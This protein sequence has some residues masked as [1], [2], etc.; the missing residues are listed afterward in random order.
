MTRVVVLTW[1]VV[2]CG[3]AAG[4]V[5][6][7]PEI[8]AART[9]AIEGGAA[10]FAERGLEGAFVVRRADDGSPYR[11]IGGARIDQRF[12]PASTFKVPNTLIGLETGVIGDATF[13]LQWDGREREIAAWNRDHDLRSAIRESVV[14]FYQEV[15]RRVGSARMREHVTALHFGNAEIGG[16]DV[17]DR[18]WLEGPLAISPR[19]QIDFLAR[20]TRGELPISA[21]SVAI[22]RDVIASEAHGDATLRW[23]TGTHPV[24]EGEPGHAWL[25][26]WVEREGEVTAHF[27]LILLADTDD[28][29]G[30]RM[31]E[32]RDL[33]IELLAR[34]RL[35]GPPGA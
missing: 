26:G 13:A 29:L 11:T 10:L 34:E 18:F 31:G 28:E 16:E 14:W 30:A 4:R 12:V 22:L 35:I 24:R 8:V 20:L 19:E 15:A 23:K 32:R 2:G 6:T 27:A 17:I 7:A 1:A 5:T 3:A 21:R 33:V 25:V 9:E